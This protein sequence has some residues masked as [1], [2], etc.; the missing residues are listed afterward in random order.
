MVNNK[1]S[2]EDNFM[3]LIT[4]SGFIILALKNRP[5]L[6]APRNRFQLS[7]LCVGFVSLDQ[8]IFFRISYLW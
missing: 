5:D 8:N 2:K 7:F 6:I 1:K 3:L 4:D